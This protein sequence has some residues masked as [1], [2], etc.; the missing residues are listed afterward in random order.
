MRAAL[1]AFV[2]TAALGFPIASHA[3]TLAE[4][5]SKVQ[6]LLAQIEVLKAQQ[7]TAAA[8]A[9]VGTSSCSTLPRNLSRGTRS[10]DVQQLQQFLIS[11]NLLASDF[12]HRFLRRSHRSRGQT[13]SMQALEHLL[14]LAV[15][16]WIR[17][18][19]AENTCKNCGGVH[20]SANYAFDTE[21]I[22]SARCSNHRR[23]ASNS[24]QYYSAGCVNMHTA[25]TAD[26]NDFLSYRT[27]RFHHADA[28]EFL[29]GRR[30][31]ADVEC[32]GDNCE[33]LPIYVPHGRDD[34]CRHAHSGYSSRRY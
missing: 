32:V 19:R 9:N 24:A 8:S 12:C 27:N 7:A 16:Q 21:H 1:I 20:E 31:D 3:A 6:S 11:Q 34:N 29:C 30:H 26:A 5:Q 28:H 22:R 14:W 33:H 17:I 4:L 10:E 18:S 15:L 13:I 23:C 25:R 2:L